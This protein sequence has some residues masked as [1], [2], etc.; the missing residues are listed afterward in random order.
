MEWFKEHADTIAIISTFAVC[1]WT[2]NE[3]INSID[4]DVGI[5]KA[6]LVMKN[7]MPQDLCKKEGK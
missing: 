5:I 7:I 2:M 4:K 3:K 6:V 1:F